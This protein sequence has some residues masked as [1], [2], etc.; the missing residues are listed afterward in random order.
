MRL[1]QGQSVLRDAL[2]TGDKSVDA[3]ARRKLPPTDFGTRLASIRKD[4]GITQVQLAQTIGAQQPTISYYE[5]NAG[6]PPAP[7]LTELARA[8]DVSADVLLGIEQERR[9]AKNRSGAVPAEKRRLWKQFQLV[10]ELSE[11]DQRSVLRFIRA[12]AGDKAKR[13]TKE[14]SA[15]R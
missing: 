2:K 4:R 9:P 10:Q 8:L 14:A 3:M 6:H 12:L 13:T 7:V 5:S 15:R 11:R 1:I